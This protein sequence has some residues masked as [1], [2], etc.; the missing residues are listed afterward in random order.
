MAAILVFVAATG[1]AAIASVTGFGIGSL[2]TPVLSLRAPLK[3]VAVVLAAL[4][5]AMT[6]QAVAG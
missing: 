4:G 1:A 2:L 6:L 5:V 3:I